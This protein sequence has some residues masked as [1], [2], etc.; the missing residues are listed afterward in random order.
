MNIH[1]IK[2]EDNFIE[3]R[4]DLKCLVYAINT[5][6]KVDYAIGCFSTSNIFAM[7]NLTIPQDIVRE[8][9]SRLYSHIPDFL[10]TY[11]AG[12]NRRIWDKKDAAQDIELSL[13]NIVQ[14][15]GEFKSCALF[16][17]GMCSVDDCIDCSRYSAYEQMLIFRHAKNYREFMSYVSNFLNNFTKKKGSK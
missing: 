17:T 12:W 5:P 14:V 8:E 15:L 1:G 9:I 3:I 16:E 11:T 6:E 10:E 7:R 2:D 13:R 4:H